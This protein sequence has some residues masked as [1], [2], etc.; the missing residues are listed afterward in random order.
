MIEIVAFAVLAGPFVTLPS[1]AFGGNAQLMALGHDPS[2]LRLYCFSTRCGDEEWH[3]VLSPARSAA[4][5]R[6]QTTS[7][8]PVLPG[9]PHGIGL[10]APTSPRHSRTSYANHWRVGTRYRVQPMR[11]EGTRLDVQLGAG[12]RLAP[13]H[14]DGVSR[15][16]PVLRGAFAL[17]QRFGERAHW[18]QQIQFETG[19]GTTFVK[20]TLGI[21]VSLW[22][23]WTLQSDFSI[24]HDEFGRSGSESAETSI[25]LRRR[26]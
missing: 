5:D 16:G 13:L 2:Q 26:F 20:Q 19:L 6:E 22:P 12:Y 1:P 17:D 14:D 3:R 23:A 18:R 15:A 8:R 7:R 24:R 11:D 4:S 9:N 21:D 25:E 10:H